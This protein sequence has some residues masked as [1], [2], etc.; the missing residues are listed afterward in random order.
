M[1]S[2][3]SGLNYLTL[4]SN[5]LTINTAFWMA[6]WVKLAAAGGGAVWGLGS[7]SSDE[8][9]ALYPHTDNTL[10]FIA[11]TGGENWCTK[12]SYTDNTW[13]LLVGTS[14]GVANRVC[15]LGS[16]AGSADTTSKTFTTLNR[17][18]VGGRMSSGGFI[19]GFT[20][21][22]AEPA[23]WSGAPSGGSIAALAGGASPAT[24]D[25]GNL[26]FHET[27]LSGVGSL[28]NNGSVTFDA[29]HPTITGGGGATF[30][31]RFVCIGA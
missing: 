13:T 8:S 10:Y 3:L 5:P 14:S 26:L 27:L 19:N 20:G 24:V 28:T 2:V 21:K 23:L 7:S 12:S 11:R 25:A 18:M 17:L 15:Y 6:I 29:D 1:S 22:A 30:R 16:S 31:R 4:G 9:Y